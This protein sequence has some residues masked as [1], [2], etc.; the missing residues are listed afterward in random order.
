MTPANPA[1]PV[2]HEVSL[3]GGP[4]SGQRGN[5][6]PPSANQTL[7][8][9]RVPKMHGPEEVAWSTWWR[10]RYVQG[11][12]AFCSKDEIAK[13][14]AA[15]KKAEDDAAKAAKAAAGGDK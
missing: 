2:P 8:I 5:S 9:P 10:R 1:V 15:L 4:L 13:A 14:K 6:F 12:A 7:S 3:R 11:D